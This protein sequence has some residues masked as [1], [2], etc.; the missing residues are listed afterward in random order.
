MPRAFVGIFLSEQTRRAVSAEM[1]RLRPL[2][3]AVAWVAPNNLHVT[4]RFLGDQTEEQLTEIVPALEEAAL[5][6]APFTMGLRGLGAFP[7][8]EHPRTLWVGIAEGSH[9]VR[10][11][12]SRVARALEAHGFPLE[13]RAWQAHVTIGRIVDERRSRR[14][15]MAE[16][17]AGLV[18]GATLGFGTMTVEAI[19]LMRSDLFPSGARYTGIASVPLRPP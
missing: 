1:D 18:R 9:E 14:E 15:G 12:Q 3:R 8:L 6:F 4:L 5:G 16:T 10:E 7:G 13:A 11:L 17:R 19:S 2:S